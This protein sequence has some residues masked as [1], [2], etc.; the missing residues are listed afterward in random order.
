MNEDSQ[1]IILF[2]GV[3]NL[4]N[5]SVNFVIKHDRKRW[6]KFAPLQSERGQTLLKAHHLPTEDFDTFILIQER[7]SFT[8]STAAL[9]VLKN[10]GGLWQLV[11]VFII[12]PRPMRDFVYQL[13]AKNRYR[14]FGKRAACMIPTED[15]KSRF[16]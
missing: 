16:L 8:K 10:L 11:Y 13:I 7:K 5:T 9:Q 1:H 3:C 14:W 15:V 6:F 2:D 4:C 12:I